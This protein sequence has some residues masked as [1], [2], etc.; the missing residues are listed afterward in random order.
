[1]IFNELLV[2]KRR[3]GFLFHRS[4]TGGGDKSREFEVVGTLL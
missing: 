2:E 1:M 4:V 3:E